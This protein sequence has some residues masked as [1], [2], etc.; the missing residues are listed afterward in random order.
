MDNLCEELDLVF[1]QFPKYCM[2]ML[3]DFNAKVGKDDIFKT[4]LGKERL[5]KSIMIT[6]TG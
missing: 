1:V 5:H 2:N 4:T 6:E 3:A